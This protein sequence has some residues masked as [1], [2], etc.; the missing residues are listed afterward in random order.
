MKRITLYIFIF[1]L[2]S[3]CFVYAEEIKE[4]VTPN[5][6]QQTEEPTGD[7]SAF[8]QDIRAT[9]GIVG[10]GYFSKIDGGEN[11]FVPSLGGIMRLTKPIII[12]KQSATGDIALLDGGISAYV[13]AASKENEDISI[14]LISVCITAGLYDGFISLSVGPT[15]AL[16]EDVNEW[17][18]GFVF[19]SDSLKF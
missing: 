13:T 17:Y 11:M 10:L 5:E 6:I 12:K 4:D 16:S 2:V 9:F 15:F 3:V 7:L 19:T 8:F 14:F 18:W 1:F